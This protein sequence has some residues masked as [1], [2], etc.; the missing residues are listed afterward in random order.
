MAKVLPAGVVNI[1]TGKGSASGNYILQHEGFR[2]LAFTGSTE[3][4]YTISEAAA[5]RLIPATLELG[6]K[7]A[8]IY[9][10]D[11]H[12]KKRLRVSNSGFSSI[13]DRCAALGS[14][15]FVHDDIYDKFLA[16]AIA[17]FENVKVGFPW[18][19]DTQMGTQVSEEQLQ[20]ILAYVEVGKRKCQGCYRCGYRL[21]EK[22][23][24]K[25]Y[26]INRN[27]PD[28]GQQQDACGLR[29]R[30]SVLWSVLSDSTMKLR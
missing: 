26:F 20:K 11:D 8:N 23:L 5:R 12:G 14:R 27:D 17:A 6:G 3:V 18:E 21:T 13:R 30:S 4:G 16:E 2:K 25:G 24:D 19:K 15:V 22:R 28:R 1:I 10:P 7:S 9:F 29:K